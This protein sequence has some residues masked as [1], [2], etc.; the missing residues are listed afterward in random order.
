[1]NANNSNKR[2]TIDKLRQEILHMQGFKPGGTGTTK[3]PGLEVIEQA[4]PNAI[5]PL[6]AVHEFICEGQEGSAASGGFIGGLL[7]LL[8]QETGAC[9][10]I[11]TSRKLFP[12]A[13]ESF[14]AAP[15]RVIFADVDK[16]KDLLWATEEALKCEGL[17]AVITEL[18][19]ITF[20]QSRRLQLAVEKSRVTSFIMRKDPARLSSTTSVARWKILPAP[21]VNEAGL[22]GVGF[23]HWQVELLKVRNGYPGCW[24]VTW[25]AGKF[26]TQ[27]KRSGALT[28]PLDGQRKTG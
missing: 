24:E 13:L 28:I 15:H 10:W 7:G 22:P 1:M 23:P 14:G 16:E 11:S 17:S 5:F 8:M 6:G 21:S 4:F 26:E 12:P 20:A 18:R 19:D 27:Q 2:D 25:S 3:M 9:L